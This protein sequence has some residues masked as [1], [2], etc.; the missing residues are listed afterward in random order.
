M[1]AV[2]HKNEVRLTT[3]LGKTVWSEQCTDWPRIWHE[4]AT[5]LGAGV[6]TLAN[7]D[8]ILKM[9]STGNSSPKD[10][11]VDAIIQWHTSIKGDLRKIPSP[12]KFFNWFRYGC[13]S[14]RDRQ[15]ENCRSGYLL[16]MGRPIPV[17]GYFVMAWSSVIEQ[18]SFH[19][20]LN[21]GNLWKP[22]KSS[23]HWKIWQQGVAWEWPALLSRQTPLFVCCRVACRT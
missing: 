18:I 19:R 8:S 3:K 15:Q 14:W 12:F 21:P 6:H 20:F 16:G 10:C 11:C 2:S 4:I 22:L 5:Q 1:K 17:L 7:I 13:H 9:P 23:K